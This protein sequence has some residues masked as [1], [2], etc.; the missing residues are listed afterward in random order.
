MKRLTILAMVLMLAAC[1]PALSEAALPAEMTGTWT[2]TGTPAGSGSPIALTLTVSANGTGSYTFVQGDY[3]ESYPFTLA[4]EAG[5]F[6]VTIPPDNLLGI[7]AC[8]GTYALADGTL[9]LDIT[10]TFATGRQYAYTAVCHK[11]DVQSADVLATFAWRQKALGIVLATDDAAIIDYN[12]VTDDPRK[13]G[14]RFVKLLF[15]STGEAMTGD[16]MN[17]FGGQ[18]ALT[19]EAGNTYAARIYTNVRITMSEK[20]G[21]GLAEK[22]PAFGLLFIAPETVALDTLRFSAEGVQ[23]ETLLQ[24]FGEGTYAAMLDTLAD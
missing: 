20:N 4:T 6:A 9:T 21:F 14:E 1:L 15:L 11:T 17:E 7:T 10:T 12:P 22:Q 16:E 3:T 24:R 19:D 13:A 5:T 23:G 2:G 8:K 18:A